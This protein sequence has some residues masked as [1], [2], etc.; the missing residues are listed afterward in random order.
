MKPSLLSNPRFLSLSSLL[1]AGAITV[2]PLQA[3]TT[4]PPAPVARTSSGLPAGAAAAQAAFLVD[5]AFDVARVSPSARPVA[6]RGAA[7][8]LPRLAVGDGAL[9]REVL[10]MRWLNFAMMPSVP[11]SV[12]Q[13]AIASFFDVAVKTDLPWA[14]AWATNIP[15]AAAR[16]GALLAISRAHERARTPNSWDRAD[17]YAVLAQRAAR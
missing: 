13:S 4:L 3:Q 16:T 17:R 14:S 1:F 7:A 5:G 2:T 15:D 10:T 8:L 9:A 11:R 12:R 6:V